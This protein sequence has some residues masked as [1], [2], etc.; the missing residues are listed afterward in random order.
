MPK[1]FAKIESGLV[2]NVVVCEDV[3]WLEQRLGGTWVETAKYDDVQRYAGIGQ[4]FF[5]DSQVKFAPQWVQPLGAEDAYPVG[6]H[7]WHNGMIWQSKVENNVWEPGVFGWFDAL[8]EVPKWIQPLGAGSEY[9]VDDE[10]MHGGRHWKS[11]TASNVWEP[12]VFGWD[13]IT[14]TSTPDQ[15]QAWVQPT[16]EHDAYALGAIV[17]HNGQTWVS[18]Y[19]AN[20]WEPGV[21]GWELQ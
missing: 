14:D 8:S 10:V 9:A 5:S 16:G 20:V 15:P 13:D 6:A 7:T 2:I 11:N 3:T 17:N 19:A 1:R 4:Y 12:G 18:Q 21:F